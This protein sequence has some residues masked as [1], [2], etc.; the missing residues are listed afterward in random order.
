MR[1]NFVIQELRY[2][3]V[4]STY[5]EAY[6][7]LVNFTYHLDG[8]IVVV[9]YY[10]SAEEDP[11]GNDPVGCLV[12]M[13]V[14]NFTECGPAGIENPDRYLNKYYPRNTY[15]NGPCGEEFF[16]LINACK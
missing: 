2:N 13:G 6:A 15:P 7:F 16:E 8:Q 14:K 5:D 4:F 3:N 11:T 12:E 9:K 10:K 1:T